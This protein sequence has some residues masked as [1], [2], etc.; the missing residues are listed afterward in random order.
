MIKLKSNE[1]LAAEA[2]IRWEHPEWGLISPMEF[3]SLAEETGIIVDIGN[4]I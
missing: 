2:L 1:I 3:I 4:W